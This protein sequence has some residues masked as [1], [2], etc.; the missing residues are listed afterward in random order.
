MI[1]VFFRD[2]AEHL[3]VTVAN[4][5][6]TAPVVATRSFT[7]HTNLDV[8]FFFFSPGGIELLQ[9][10]R[11]RKILTKSQFLYLIDDIY[12]WISLRRYD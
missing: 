8:G 6:S 2:P 12:E 9:P 3:V 5:F 10:S 1:S 4:L 11:K 7:N